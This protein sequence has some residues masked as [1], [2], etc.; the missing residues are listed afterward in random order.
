MVVW[1]FYNKDRPQGASGN[2]CKAFQ[3]GAAPTPYETAHYDNRNV[4]AVGQLGID[5]TDRLKANIGAGDSWDKTTACGGQFADNQFA[6]FEDCKAIGNLG[7]TTDG[8]GVIRYKGEERSE[9][10]RVGKECVS[11]CRA[12][13]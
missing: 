8:I 10:R 12:R 4:G 7:V 13:W 6:S 1:A 5:L 9:E 11:T 2:G 3:P